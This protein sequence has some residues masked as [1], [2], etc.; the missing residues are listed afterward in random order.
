MDAVNRRSLSGLGLGLILISPCLAEN[1]TLHKDDIIPVKFNQSLSTSRSQVNDKFQASVTDGSILPRGSY[2]QGIVTKS[3]PSSDGNDAVMDL[4]FTAIHFPD[5]TQMAIDAVPIPLDKKYVNKSKSGVYTAKSS[6]SDGTLVGAG[7]LGGLLIGTILHKPF[8]GTFLGALAGVIFASSNNATK[9]DV[10]LKKGA[11]AGA[12]VLEDSSTTEINSGNQENP[13]VNDP[14]S[15]QPQPSQP[16]A[17]RPSPGQP[18]VISLGSTNLKFGANE[19]PYRDGDVIMVPLQTSANQLNLTVENSGGYIFVDSDQKSLRIAE[20]SSKYLL[21]GN[22]GQLLAPVT[23]R[24][25][26]DYLP[27]EVLAKL[28]GLKL[29][30]SA[31]N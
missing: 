13:V 21:D 1:I 19:Q 27:V 3:I 23:I 6:V 22:E 26:A 29:Q 15:S 9:G 18:I 11:E 16:P 12:L 4:Q 2:F 30:T 14:P 17:S 28:T 10:T 5:G 24:S 7:A 20:N 25:G 31:Q 8:E